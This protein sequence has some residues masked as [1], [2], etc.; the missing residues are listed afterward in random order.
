[1]NKSIVL[2]SL[3]AGLLLCAPPSSQ[4]QVSIPYTVVTNDPPVYGPYNGIFLADGEGLYK[5]LTENDTV[6]LAD[7]PWTIYAWVNADEAVAK[8]TLIAGLGKPEDEYARYLAV[9]PGKLILFGGKDNSLEGPVT[10]RSGQ[11]APGRCHLR[12]RAI[13]PLLRWRSSSER[14][15]GPGPRSRRA[16][17]GPVGIACAGVGTFR[18][19]NC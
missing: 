1:M 6:L 13:S 8:P 5:K 12:R 2:L 11:V 14:Q 4:A 19:Q 17:H 15:P 3:A 18:G 7:S 9:T 16:G 10:L